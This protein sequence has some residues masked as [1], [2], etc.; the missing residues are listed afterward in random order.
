MYLDAI[1]SLRI[2]VEDKGKARLI[3][4]LEKAKAE[5]RWS[6]WTSKT[7][8]FF[9]ANFPSEF[10]KESSEIRG[11]ADSTLVPLAGPI[12][13]VVKQAASTQS[14]ATPAAQPQ[15]NKA[16]PGVWQ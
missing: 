8:D 12:A 9:A 6:E 4:A 11:A 5:K 7:V 16:Q 2:P 15:E 14:E 13:P 3:A 1:D 10:A